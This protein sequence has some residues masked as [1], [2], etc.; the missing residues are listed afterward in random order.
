MKFTRIREILAGEWLGHPPT[1]DQECRF[2]GAADLMSDVLAF[3][4]SADCVLLTGLTNEQA[5]RTAEMV[6]IPVVVFVRGKVPPATVIALAAEKGIVLLRTRCT[7][8]EAC[9]RLYAAGLAPFKIR[10]EREAAPGT[11]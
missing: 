3:V 10:R 1:A 4:T 11:S 5:V 2:G 9:G 6:D 7:M 8:Y